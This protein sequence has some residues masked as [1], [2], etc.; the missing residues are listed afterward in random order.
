MKRTQEKVIQ[1]LEKMIEN[2]RNVK[3]IYE[4][5]NDKEEACHYRGQNNGLQQCLFIL[6][7]KKYFEELCN[8]FGVK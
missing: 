6:K 7:D 2:T 3:K 1:L 5:L 8:I 4:D